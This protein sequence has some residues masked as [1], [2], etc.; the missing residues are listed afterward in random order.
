MLSLLD[1][2]G[3]RTALCALRNTVY[4]MPLGFA[5]AA[6][7]LTTDAFAW[8]AAAI[9]G[10][11]GAAAA[12]FARSPSQGS[13]RTLFKASLL[14]LPLLMG[15]MLVRPRPLSLGLCRLRARDG[16]ADYVCVSAAG[17]SDTTVA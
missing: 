7:G 15:A 13:A 9:T 17:L 16:N 6:V 3:R 10:A 12:A 14:H 11:M 8:G 4:L 1:Q 2:T 5:A